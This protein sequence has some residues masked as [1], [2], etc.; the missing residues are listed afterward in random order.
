MKKT[1]LA[2]MAILVLM[3][4]TLFAS[5]SQEAA[6]AATEDNAAPLKAALLTSG[7]INDGGWNTFAYEGLVSLKDDYGFEIANTENVQQSAQKSII[8]NYAKKGYNLI[9]GHGYEYGE[10]LM[11]VAPDFPDIVFYNVG[12]VAMGDNVGSGIFAS[13]GLAYIVAELAAKFTK[14][15]KIGFVGAMEIPTIV[16]EVAMIKQTVSEI[17]PDAT[18][19]TAY[20]GSWT[21]VNKGKEAAMAQINQGCDVII[22]IGD[23]VDF[24]AIKA[25][26][27]KGVYV[28]GWVGDF[29]KLAPQTVLCSGV[30]DVQRIIKLQG[31][32][33]AEGT[34]KPE[35]L[36]FGVTNGAQYMGTWS[37]VVPE[38]LKAEILATQERI[39]SGE[40]AP[41]LKE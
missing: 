20:T 21:D 7:P 32:A 19:T 31:K 34:W 29:N 14:T 36:E 24:G 17:N 27:E 8:R 40:F 39:K 38:D 13:D 28:I 5:G 2:L 18:V 11:Q 22:G 16:N 35:H 30:Q 33:V 4:G 37:S 15:D 9:I 23:A 41:K 26:E 6:P 25:A 10:A 3:T 1:A 12:G